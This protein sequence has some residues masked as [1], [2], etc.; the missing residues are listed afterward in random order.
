MTICIN[1]KPHLKITRNSAAPNV[2]YDHYCGAVERTPTVDP[3]TGKPC[4]V[5]R[6]HLGQTYTT[7]DRYHNCR[8]INKGNCK[9]YMERQKEAP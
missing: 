3:V 8:D 7:E 4:F 5:G 9:Y 2:S 1:C 6:E